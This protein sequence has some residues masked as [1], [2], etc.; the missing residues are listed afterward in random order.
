MEDFMEELLEKSIWK[1]GHARD[2]DGT[3]SLLGI[4]NAITEQRAVG[5][6]DRSND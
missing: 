4:V 2:K 6:L 3:R 1:G 5:D